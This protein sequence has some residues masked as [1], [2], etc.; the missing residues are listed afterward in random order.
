MYRLRM[1]EV[2][3]ETAKKDDRLLSEGGLAPF[4]RWQHVKKL[5][6]RA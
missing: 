6:L 3:Q 2:W 1:D 4:V 5:Y